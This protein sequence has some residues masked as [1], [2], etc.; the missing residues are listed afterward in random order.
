MNYR[1]WR[2]RAIILLSL[3]ASSASP[4][5]ADV[6]LPNVIG[7]HMVLQ[8]DRP[9]PIWGWADAGEAVTVRLDEAVA[10]AT[11]DSQ[12]NWTALLPAV[13]ADRRT[14]RLSVRGKNEIVFTD[15]LIGDVWLGSGQS[16]MEMGIT[17]CDTAAAEVAAAG[18]PK[19]RLLLVPK[20]R[21]DKPAKDVRA[22]WVV[23]S[24]QTVVAGG[25]GGFSAALYYF[26]RQLQRE[27]DVPIGLVECA[28]G[29]S[30]I[31]PWTIAGA[32]AGPMYNGMI[33]P[34]RPLAIRGVVWYQGETN[35]MQRDGMRYYEK[36]QALIEGWRRAW[37][38]QFPFYFVEL[39]P[40]AG[41]KPGELPALWEA[42]TAS[43][44]I[45]KTGM[46]V[47]TDLVR[48]VH[49]IHPSNKIDVGKRLA[50]W[51]LA[52]EY[53]RRGVVYSGPIYKGMAIEGGAIRIWFAHLGS[54]LASRDGKSLSDFQI[55][56]ADGKFVAA[57][58]RID[59]NAI[60]VAAAAVRR[61]TQVQFG[62]DKRANPNLINREGLPAAPFRTKD[63]HGGTG[64]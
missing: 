1:V 3:L 29:G 41:Y 30:A 33:A 38:Y 45:P 36:M 2:S 57:R 10:T 46:A 8:R 32:K 56:G 63:W 40:Y 23:C 6:T 7:S 28:W 61:P 11:A 5:R 53:G 9:L 60:V 51:A 4:V 59:G 55:A 50:L 48:N 15:I 42:Q 35:A 20:T 44:K 54:G 31:E 37:G 22:R 24:P 13:K 47:V 62:W 12:G 17:R 58:A 52:R 49:D 64:E 39:A 43:L 27:L 18:C 34:V 16:N 21:S 26:G 25:W 19:I 14:H